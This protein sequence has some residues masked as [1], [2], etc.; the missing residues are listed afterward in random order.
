VTWASRRNRRRGDERNARS[1]SKQIVPRQNGGAD[2]LVLCYHAVDE[3]WPVDLSVAEDKFERQ[4][5][6]LL[7][8]GYQAATFHQAVFGPTPQRTLAI[9]FDDG[10]RSVAERAFP[11]LAERGL[12]ATVFVPTSFIDAGTAASWEGVSHWL[13]TE[14]ERKMLPLTRAE[15]LELSAAGWE[16]GSHTC[17]HPHLTRLGDDELA[18]ELAESRRR[19]GEV[20]GRPCVTLAYPYGDWDE[21]VRRAADRA[22]YEAAC[23]LPRRFPS[24]TPLAWPRVGIWRDDGDR[25]FAFKVSPTLRRVRRSPLWGI[26]DAARLTLGR[27]AAS[28]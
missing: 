20:L 2:V 22:G 17:T 5:D 26:V 28:P 10:F 14:H 25:T 23:S 9:T 6:S 7:S 24:P 16:V 4:L 8:R 1:P 27:L 18:W 3:T 19:C 11:L 13:G 21:R 15:L 12:V